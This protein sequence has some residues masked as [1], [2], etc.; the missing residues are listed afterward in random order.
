MEKPIPVEVVEA[1]A[2]AAGTEPDAL[3][4]TLQDHV[5]TEALVALTEHDDASWTLSFEVPN[6]SVTV[7]GDGLILVDGDRQRVWS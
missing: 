6:H 3:Q 4:F 2:D 1:V 5:P 7:R